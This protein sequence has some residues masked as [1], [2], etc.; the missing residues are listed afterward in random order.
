MNK[1]KQAAEQRAAEAPR[2]GPYIERKPGDALTFL[3]PGGGEVT[4]YGNLDVS[5]AYATKGLKSDYGDCHDSTPM[6]AFDPTTGGVTNTGPHCFAGGRLQ[7]ISA[8][9]DFRV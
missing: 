8:G 7:G 6:A 9:V 5:F 2:G 3:V 4:L 1:Q